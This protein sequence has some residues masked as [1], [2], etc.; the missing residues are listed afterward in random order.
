MAVQFPQKIKMLIAEINK[1]KR[2]MTLMNN[3]G[4]N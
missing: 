4:V 2:T 1:E 3:N